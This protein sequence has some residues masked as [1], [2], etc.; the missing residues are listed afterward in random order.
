MRG[1]QPVDLSSSSSDGVPLTCGNG[2]PQAVEQTN[3]DEIG[4]APESYR[5]VVRGNVTP[6]DKRPKRTSLGLRVCFG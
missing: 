5:R 4:V 3:S 2:F 1:V 6:S